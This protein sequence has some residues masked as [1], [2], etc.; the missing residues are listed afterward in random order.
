MWNDTHWSVGRFTSQ[1]AASDPL[2]T[3]FHLLSGRI[4]A[5]ATVKQHHKTLTYSNCEWHDLSLAMAMHVLKLMSS[6]TDY[7]LCPV[8]W[9]WKMGRLEAP[10]GCYA[11][12]WDRNL[13]S[14]AEGHRHHGGLTRYTSTHSLTGCHTATC[15]LIH[16][17][18]LLHAA[19]RG[20]IYAAHVCYLTAGTPFGV[21]T[22]KAERLV[23]LSSSHRWAIDYLPLT[24]HQTEGRAFILLL[25][26]CACLLL[27]C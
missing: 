5:V 18:A 10:S 26:L 20:L 3:L 7:V 25:K 23:L 24:A 12:Q 14:V 8:L 17:V 22:Q 27:Y 15:T 4:P 2:Q 21:F 1:L 6:F 9:T 13:C 16:R 19:S 11:L